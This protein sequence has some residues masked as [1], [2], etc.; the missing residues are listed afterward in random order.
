MILENPSP[1]DGFCDLLSKI[2]A[3]GKLNRSASFYFCLNKNWVLIFKDKFRR[4]ESSS[5]MAYGGPK[6]LMEKEKLTKHHLGQ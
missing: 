5:M 6:G 3:P 1:C 2:F 4:W